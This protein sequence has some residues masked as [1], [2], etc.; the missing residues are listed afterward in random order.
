MG[1]A[2]AYR[3]SAVLLAPRP[4]AV[5]M[6]KAR[7]AA[8]VGA[9]VLV[10]GAV[11]HLKPSPRLT[12]DSFAS[13]VY[14]NTPGAGVTG[15]ADEIEKLPVCTV[16]T[17]SALAAKDTALDATVAPAAN[18]VFDGK[19]ALYVAESACICG[20]FALTRGRVCEASGTANPQGQSYLPRC[21]PLGTDIFPEYTAGCWCGSDEDFTTANNKLSVGPDVGTLPV[22]AAGAVTETSEYITAG[23]IVCMKGET[24]AAGPV[25]NDAAGAAVPK[26][27]KQSYVWA[28]PKFAPNAAKEDKMVVCKS[29]ALQKR[30]CDA[31][32][33]TSQTG[34]KPK[35]KDM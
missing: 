3:S 5:L 23:D 19:L 11:I 26:K 7:A 31:A 15:T 8:G 27:Y 1:K 34:N 20:K 28:I 21:P 2:Q 33:S 30:Q 32:A 10:V 16:Q 13:A 22:A 14:T 29:T 12:A 35:C 17:A 6:T 24:C 25:C 9:T 4:S 18:S